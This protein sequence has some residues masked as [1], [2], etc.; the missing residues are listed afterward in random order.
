[1]NVEM[2]IENGAGDIGDGIV[3]DDIGEIKQIRI[4]DVLRKLVTLRRRDEY[5]KKAMEM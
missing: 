1:M 5:I 2:N 4:G 3:R